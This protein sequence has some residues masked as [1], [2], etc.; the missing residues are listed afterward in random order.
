VVDWD[1]IVSRYGPVVFGTA[2]RILGN[3]ADAEE[4]TQDVFLQA[5]QTARSAQVRSWPALLRRLASC[6]AL[7]R[8]RVRKRTVA[9]HNL[10]LP[11]TVGGPEQIAVGK[12]LAERLREA[13]LHLPR[14]EAAAF[15]LR[16]FEDLS[17][18]EIADAL[19]TTP[20]AAGNALF[21]ARQHL[22]RCLLEPSEESADASTRK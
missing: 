17:Y 6:R 16:Y 11:T 14:Q 7:D 8:L 18:Q 15:C 3:T 1:Q 10:D 22:E 19:H 9:L 12:E 2:W 5:Y 4:V 21:K 13:L 20:G